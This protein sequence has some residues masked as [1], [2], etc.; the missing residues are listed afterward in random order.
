MYL[1]GKKT[2]YVWRNLSGVHGTHRGGSR[3]ASKKVHFQG[4]IS[5]SKS[6]KEVVRGSEC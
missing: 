6:S 5:K 1:E 4:N 3:V 2:V